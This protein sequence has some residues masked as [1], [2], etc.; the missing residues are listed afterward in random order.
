MRR[1]VI[2][3]GGIGDVILSLPALQLLAGPDDEIWVPARMVPLIR[4]GPRARA[5]SATGLDLLGVTDPPAQLVD[6]LR[7]FDSIVSWYGA[8]RPEFRDTVAGLGLPFT[9]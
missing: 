1:L 5:I 9:F 2:R 6:H 7:A 8:N 4:F 3:P